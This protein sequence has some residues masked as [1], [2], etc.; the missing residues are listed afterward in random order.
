MIR[1]AVVILNWNG[2]S[3]LEQFLPDVVK[4]TL[5]PDTS[6]SLLLTTGLKMIPLL[7]VTENH[8]GGGGHQA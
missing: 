2:R 3:F 4:N 5:A 6:K 7:W 1:T 8:P